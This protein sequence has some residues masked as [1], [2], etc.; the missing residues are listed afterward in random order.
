MLALPKVSMGMLFPQRL[1]SGT[2]SCALPSFGK[3]ASI[4]HGSTHKE[5]GEEECGEGDEGSQDHVRGDLCAAAPQDGREDLKHYP[6]QEHEVDIGQSQTQ[7]VENRVLHRCTWRHRRD[8]LTNPDPA[9]REQ[10]TSPAPN[11]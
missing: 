10:S 5:G 8:T 11:K 4:N 6:D 3:L 2:R 9:C 1:Q 7:L